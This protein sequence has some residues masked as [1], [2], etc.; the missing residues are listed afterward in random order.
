[1]DA[2]FDNQR[3][4]DKK[5]RAMLSMLLAEDD[6]A[7]RESLVSFFQSQGFRVFPAGSGIEAVEIAIAKK[8]SFSVMDINMPGLSGI[9]AFKHISSELGM[10]P[11]I[12]M[13]GDR[14]ED[15]MLRAL[16]AGGFSFLSKP[17]HI[18]L[19][20]RSVDQLIRRFFSRLE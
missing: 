20:R 10:M 5:L 7:H 8:V 16:E 6:D 1:M 12:F 11:C 19:M 3:P 4:L 14:S 18:D 15:I 13:S 17:I 2:Q 9:E